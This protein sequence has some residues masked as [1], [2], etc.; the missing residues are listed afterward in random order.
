MFRAGARLAIVLV[1]AL[2]PVPLAAQAE[3]E[4]IGR[5]LA[6]GRHPWSA[7]PDFDE[8]RGALDEMYAAR[9]Y[10]PLW[11]AGPV[12]TRA[13]QEAIAT[14]ARAADEGL[15]PADYDAADLASVARQF[16][17][18]PSTP[19]ERGRFDLLLSLDLLRHLDDLDRGRVRPNPIQGAGA[20]V[21]P[22][23]AAEIAR[24]A[25]ADTVASLVAATEPGLVQYRNLKRFLPLMRA[26]AGDTTLIPPPRGRTVR[27]GDRYE[28]L[29]AL[30]RLLTAL[31]D[32]P[33]GAA[34]TA[35]SYGGAVEAA[36]RRFQSRHG[37]ESD[38][39][40][41]PLTQ[42]ALRV[43]L[44]WRARQVELAMERLRW[45]PPLTGRALVVNIP[46]FHL[47]GFDSIGMVGGPQLDMRVVVGRALDTRTPM[48]LEDLRYVEFRPYWYLPRSIVV[49]EIVPALR[50]WP[51]YLQ[52]NRMELVGAKGVAGADRVTS[53]D[54]DRLLRG[55]LGVRQQPGPANALGLVKFVFPNRADVYMHDT[56]S[57]ELFSR[58]RRDFSHGCIRV[59]DPAGLAEWVLRDEAGWSREQIVAAMEGKRTFRVPLAQ[60]IPV[61]IFYT[62]VA[63][64]ADGTASFYADI[65]G[66]DQRLDQALKAE[67]RT[68]AA[69]LVSVSRRD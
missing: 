60:P 44:A 28:G 63:V 27:P 5:L 52:W 7:W 4:V 14:L 68:P 15:I 18:V 41:W 10:A 67:R 62:T 32:L 26:L 50:R 35:T 46:A 25:E 21:R 37:L 38:G 51:G 43:P 29:P 12:P 42:E 45:L 24:A 8:D 40:L 30:V 13:A 9:G 55:E 59:E 3:S 65:Y 69:G 57:T 66:N 31:G 2:G 11:L 17:M 61:A 48:L 34:D 64:R 53:A 47:F 6:A 58:T 1:L 36:V 49:N 16:R 22:G 54:I 39:I 33:P 23:L 19:E 20:G 56:P